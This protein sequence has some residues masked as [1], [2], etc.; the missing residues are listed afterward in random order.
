MFRRCNGQGEDGRSSKE[1]EAPK[2]VV[3]K[4]TAVA[5]ECC[6]GR[7][8]RASISGGIG[9]LATCQKKCEANKSCI[10]IEFGRRLR[11][12][13]RTCY[14]SLDKCKCYLVTKGCNRVKR[15]HGYNIFKP[16]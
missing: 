4:R 10:A 3:W 6:V 8:C 7:N 13:R 1:E 15:H 5:K 11:G 16:Q 14:R 12:R 9:S 2:K